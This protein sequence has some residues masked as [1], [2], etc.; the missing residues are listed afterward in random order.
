MET[1][2]SQVI[3]L[4]A[5]PAGATA[6]LFLSKAGI[7]HTII[8]K[9][10]FPRDKICGDALSGKVLSVLDHLDKNIFNELKSQIQNYEPCHGIK[11]VSPGNHHLD[12][13]IKLRNRKPEDSHGFV[14]TRMNFDHF[15]FSKLNSEFSHVI[16]E[17]EVFK[18]DDV[19]NHQRR[20][21]YRRNNSEFSVESSLIIL[22]DGAQSQFSRQ[23]LNH[24][25]EDN[26]YCAG[27]RMYYE[28]VNGFNDKGYIELHFQKEVLPG[29]IWLFPMP[30]NTAN[31]GIG[32]LTSAVQKNKINLKVALQNAIE[33]H[34]S[35]K[36]RFANAKVI[37]G[38]KGWG[39]PLGSKKRKLLTDGLMA[40]GDAASLIDPFTG[41]GIGNAMSSGM[42]AAQVAEKA[43]KE[44]NFSEEILREYETTFYRRNWS[45]L[46]LSH[47]LQKLCKHQ[48]LFNLVVKK[49]SRSKELQ[50]LISSMFED[51][52]VRK[53]L[54]NPMFYLRILFA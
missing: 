5:G 11:F 35:L 29:Y 43:L 13:D 20:V 24:K 52:D 1:K 18:I 53:K 9:A 23:F 25:K 44:N 45:E 17:A 15:L 36:Q 16:D 8:D 33:N 37:D 22:A 41:E 26:H 12:I 47:T 39:L 30:N 28:N 51:I 2:F 14:A 21:F 46:K 42:I 27:I 7:H 32:M 6:S 40:C 19:A 54:S 50:I 49:A 34:P 48:W 10:K 4:G 31:V 3:I 38:M